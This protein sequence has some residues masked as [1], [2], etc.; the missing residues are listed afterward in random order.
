MTTQK[1][2]SIFQEMRCQERFGRVRDDTQL[3]CNKEGMSRKMSK[4]AATFQQECTRLDSFV[5]QMMVVF[6]FI[7]RLVAYSSLK[8]G[9]NDAVAVDDDACNK[10][11]RHT[12]Y[13]I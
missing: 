10:K 13:V 4:N 12:V 11:G 6:I 9:V 3:F 1:H 7:S 2:K 5:L 8:E